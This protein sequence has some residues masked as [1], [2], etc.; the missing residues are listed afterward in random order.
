M[1]DGAPIYLFGRS[2]ASPPIE[3]EDTLFYIADL[4]AELEVIA[5]QGNFGS[6]SVLLAITKAEARRLAETSDGSR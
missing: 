4:L 1:S 6:L 5:T 2:K 3:S